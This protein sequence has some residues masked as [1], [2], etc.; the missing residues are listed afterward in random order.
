MTKQ[1]K[2]TLFILILIIFPS[3]SYLY[4]ARGLDI[5]RF[6][7]YLKIPAI[8][9][10]ASLLIFPNV[11]K[12]QKLM[13]KSNISA[14]HKRVLFLDHD[15]IEC[16]RKRG[17]VFRLAFG[18][19]PVLYVLSDI[20]IT[21]K[22]VMFSIFPFLST[23]S[24]SM[25]YKKIETIPTYTSYIIKLKKNKNNIHIINSNGESVW[26]FTKNQNVLTEIESIASKE[27]SL[28]QV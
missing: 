18:I 5:D 11:P 2:I 21:N 28:N 17:I 22:R 9:L 25:F 12:I 14:I 20:L 4:F 16:F 26:I 3:L 27:L 8:I 6:L 19:F 1:N 10:G 23:P 7:D 15:E 24:Y 13:R